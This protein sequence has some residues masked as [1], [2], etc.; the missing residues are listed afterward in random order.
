MKLSRFRMQVWE[1]R[2]QSNRD[3]DVVAIAVEV[4]S[5]G[6]NGR[7][8]TGLGRP[9]LRFGVARTPRKRAA[10]YCAPA[11]LLPYPEKPG[12]ANPNQNPK[13]PKHLRFVGASRNAWG[14]EVSRASFWR[15]LRRMHI[16]ASQ[17]WCGE[18][19]QGGLGLDAC[20]GYGAKP[21]VSQTVPKPKPWD[22][23]QSLRVVGI[24]DEAEEAFRRLHHKGLLADVLA[25]QHCVGAPILKGFGHHLCGHAIPEGQSN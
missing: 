3:N 4:T 19:E 22:S 5:N 12:F 13:P 21:A 9:P 17:G 6:S 18:S 8:A 25:T 23:K 2:P 15:P 16:F 11:T 7:K 20:S 24:A 1:H 14:S 10:Q